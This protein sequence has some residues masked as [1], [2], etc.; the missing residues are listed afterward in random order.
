MGQVCE[1]LEGLLSMPAKPRL[2]ALQVDASYFPHIGD[3]LEPSANFPNTFKEAAEAMITTGYTPGLWIA[4]LMAGNRS[5]VVRENPEWLLKDA[6]GKPMSR[7]LR[8]LGDREWGLPDEEIMVLDSSHPGAMDYL[9][10]VFR[11]FRAW[12]IRLY[13]TDFMD[14]GLYDSTQVQRHTPGKTGQQYMREVM[15]MIREEIGEDSYWLGCILPFNAALGFCDGMRIGNDV[16]AL[17][18]KVSAGNMVQE[19]LCD[20]YF[21]NIWWQND[22][23]VLYL[24]HYHTFLSDAEVYAL[25]LL[26]AMTGGALTTSDMPHLLTEE[27]L[28]LWKFIEPSATHFTGQVPA[29]AEQVAVDAGQRDLKILTRTGERG[30]ITALFFNGSESKLT[31]M[32]SL[33][34]VTGRDERF[35]AFRWNHLGNERLTR[36]EMTDQILVQLPPHGAELIYLTRENEAPPLRLFG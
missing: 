20:Q 33:S 10:E 6:E 18:S 3:W 34:Q 13:K 7:W 29:W 17:W 30:H 26:S 12:G 28:K 21:N 22:P 32:V 14:W 1:L 4:P 16:P 11:T 35:F 15:A 31:E 19:A 2:D 23:D 36:G 24:R 5:K 9:R 8:Y 25:A 27:R